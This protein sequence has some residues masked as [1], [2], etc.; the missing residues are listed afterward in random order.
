MG[1]MKVIVIPPVSIKDHTVVVPQVMLN[2][3]LYT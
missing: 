2:L 1:I 3:C